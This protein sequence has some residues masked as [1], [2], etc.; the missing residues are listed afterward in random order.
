MYTSFLLEYEF[1]FY[2]SLFVGPGV[3][4]LDKRQ[5]THIIGAHEEV[6]ASPYGSASHL[7]SSQFFR[8]VQ[9]C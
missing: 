3:R 5:S 7:Q 2:L 1:N 8:V 9:N 4:A 6:Y